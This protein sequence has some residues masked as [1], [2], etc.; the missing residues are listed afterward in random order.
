MLCWEGADSQDRVTQALY[1]MI[2]VYTLRPDKVF[3]ACRKFVGAVFGA[4]HHD[5]NQQLLNLFLLFVKFKQSI[6]SS[7]SSVNLKFCFCMFFTRLFYIT[8]HHI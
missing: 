5:Y 1:K 2:Y 4:C 7:V 3:G 8:T 6:Y